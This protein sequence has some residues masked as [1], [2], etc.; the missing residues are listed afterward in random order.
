MMTPGDRTP[1]TKLTLVLAFQ[2]RVMASLALSAL[3]FAEIRGMSPARAVGEVLKKGEGLPE[4]DRLLLTEL[5]RAGHY[6]IR[7]QEKEG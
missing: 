3:E 2:G 7:C 1:G 6:Q 4:H 5:I